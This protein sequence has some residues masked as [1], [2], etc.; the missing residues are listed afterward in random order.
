M[1]ENGSSENDDNS[2]ES[3]KN[4]VDSEKNSV[5]SE[6][7]THK[8]E[9]EDEMDNNSTTTRKERSRPKKLKKKTKG[10]S[11]LNPI[12]VSRVRQHM[13]KHKTK[14]HAEKRISPDTYSVMSTILR[15]I[16]QDITR[17]THA[18]IE[19]T[20]SSAKDTPKIVNVRNLEKVM[21]GDVELRTLFPQFICSYQVGN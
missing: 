6:N 7:L 12:P 10:K 8:E 16:I 1:S 5:D 13:G 17:K 21:Q 19:Q 9:E 4:S 20:N 11:I 14:V 15:V 2:V 3:E 18:H